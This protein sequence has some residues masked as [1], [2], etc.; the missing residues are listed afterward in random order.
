ML[1]I[2]VND[3]KQ[4]LDA[5]EKPQLIDVRE[6]WELEICQLEGVKNL[7]M[8]EIS[9]RLAEVEK[10]CE[11]VVICHH[12]GRSEQVARWLEQQGCGEMTNLL[13]GVDAW[14]ASIDTEMA[15]Y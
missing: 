6:S 7:P 2:S 15:R 13:G 1:E 14:A 10:D 11:T 8:S 3:L 5:G 9:Q 4:K 12:G